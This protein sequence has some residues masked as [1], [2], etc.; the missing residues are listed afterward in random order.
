MALS[1]NSGR[2]QTH[3]HR[4]IKSR[5]LPIVLVPV[6]LAVITAVAMGCFGTARQDKPGS[7]EA[8]SEPPAGTGLVESALP[9][10]LNP[11]SSNVPA[12]SKEPERTPNPLDSVAQSLLNSMSIEEKIYQLFIVTPEQLCDVSGTVTQA[13]PAAQTALQRHPVG[14]VSFFSGNIQTPEQ[15]TRL[16]EDLQASSRLGLFIAVDEEGGIVARLGNN[17]KMGTTVFP[18]MGR[19]GAS[20]D[21][22]NALNVGLTIG[23]ELRQ[24]GFNLNFAPVADVNSNPNN[25]VIANRSFSSNPQIA[26]N[27]VAACVSG[28]KESGV[29]CTLKHFPGHGDTE[30]DSHY[31]VASSNKTIEELWNCEF[32]PFQY[33]IA[34]GADMIMIGHISL[35]NVIGNDTPASLSYEITTGILREQLGFDGLIITDSMV[36]EAITNRFSSV[37]A[38]VQAIQA[39]ADIILMPA[40]IGDAVNGILDAVKSGELTEKRIDESVYRILYTKLA[41]G[42]IPLPL[43][44]Q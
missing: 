38:A 3:R 18:P 10:A 31:G 4:K 29:L 26:A 25:P 17:P 9:D 24:F 8:E 32:L 39:G 30:T 35:P 6:V 14:G 16:I 12:E 23:N 33:G 27:M 13:E 1:K 44:E 40:N 7:G 5:L 21:T 11:T 19:I 41:H 20:G 37:D 42:I 15:I 36:M 34:A 22:E 43:G 2:Q 28:F